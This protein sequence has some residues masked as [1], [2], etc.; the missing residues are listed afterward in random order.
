MTWQPTPERVNELEL[1]VFGPD[2]TDDEGER[3]IAREQIRQTLSA[4]VPEGCVPVFP[5]SDEL[6]A[7]LAENK[8]VGYEKL[9]AALKEAEGQS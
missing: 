8:G 1:E 2:W 6:E 4:F 3:E 9:D 5:T 7:W